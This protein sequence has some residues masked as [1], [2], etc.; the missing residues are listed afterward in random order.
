M[1][2][3]FLHAKEIGSVLQTLS[4]NEQTGLP[5]SQVIAVREQFGWNEMSK[6]AP[7]SVW[8]R[9]LTQFSDLVVWILIVM[10]MIV[11]ARKGDLQ[12][13]HC[14]TAL[15]SAPPSLCRQTAR[16]RIGVAGMVQGFNPIT[17]RIEILGLS[18]DEIKSN[19]AALGGSLLSKPT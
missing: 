12:L 11:L 14:V 15:W 8:K 7:E 17:C 4:S 16:D 2:D 19:L 1:S 6:V 3:S 18:D 10:A 5:E 13:R 9:F